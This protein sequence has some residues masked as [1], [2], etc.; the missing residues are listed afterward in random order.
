VL[1]QEISASYGGPLQLQGFK[2][3]SPV[4]I[5][6]KIEYIRS[7][8]CY[9]GKTIT[10]RIDDSTYNKIKSAAKSEKRTISNFMEYA[11]MAYLENTSFISDEEMNQIIEDH[12][13]MN[14]LQQSVQD[15]K[16]GNYRIVE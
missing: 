4:D 10:I 13:L 15:I 9:M 8:S 16:R 2:I 3:A 12:E 7:R 11:T 6:N 14:R 1:E 5:R